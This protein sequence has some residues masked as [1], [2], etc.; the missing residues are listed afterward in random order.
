MI[1][2]EKKK[3]IYIIKKKPMCDTCLE[4]LTRLNFKEATRPTQ[5]IYQCRKCK[6]KYY[7]YSY[8]LADEIV[9]EE[10]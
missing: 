5:D 9:D 10:V 6:K 7:F 3:I 4:E 2:V 8:E 1:S